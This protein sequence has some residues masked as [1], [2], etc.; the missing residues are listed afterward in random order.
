MLPERNKRANKYHT[1]SAFARRRKL[2]RYVS[3]LRFVEYENERYKNRKDGR[4]EE[5]NIINC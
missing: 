2:Q 5:K 1:F 4:D 3:V